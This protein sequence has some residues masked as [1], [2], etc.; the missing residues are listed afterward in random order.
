MQY[1]DTDIKKPL[2]WNGSEWIDMRITELDA[3]NYIDCGT[4]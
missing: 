4:Y 3:N 1:Y 2:W